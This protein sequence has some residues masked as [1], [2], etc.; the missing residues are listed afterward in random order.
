MN[1]FAFGKIVEKFL[2]D[3]WARDLLERYKVSSKRKGRHTVFSIIWMN[4]SYITKIAEKEC[5]TRLAAFA[6]S[7]YEKCNA[8]VGNH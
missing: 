1:P 6:C 4:L 5:F 2:C 8:L 3:Y 7:P